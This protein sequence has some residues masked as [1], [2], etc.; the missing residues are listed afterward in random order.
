MKKL[1]KLTILIFTMS[2]IILLQNNFT[3]TIATASNNDNNNE[4]ITYADGIEWR[5]KLINGKLYK[6]QYNATTKKWIGNWIP[7]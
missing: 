6:R 7:A 2:G 4:I 1:N 5:Y 3:A